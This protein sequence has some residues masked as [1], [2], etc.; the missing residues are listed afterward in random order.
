MRASPRSVN[1]HLQSG[2]T[3]VCSHCLD[4]LI[5]SLHHPPFHQLHPPRMVPPLTPGH[6]STRKN[7]LTWTLAGV[8]FNN[9]H[10]YVKPERSLLY[11]CLPTDA[12]SQSVSQTETMKRRDSGDPNTM[13]MFHLAITWS[14]SSPGLAHAAAMPLPLKN[15][16]PYLLTT[17]NTNW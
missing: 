3:G 6:T 15:Y 4:Q 14:V 8:I 12:G 11:H 16:S 7:S 2:L 9:A 5:L 1:T 17:A 13:A 10:F